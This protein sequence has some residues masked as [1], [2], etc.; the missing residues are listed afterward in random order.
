MLYVDRETAKVLLAEH[1]IKINQLV[2]E[3]E[4]K[5]QTLADEYTLKIIL[6]EIE[7]RE[8]ATASAVER[9]E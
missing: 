1:Q 7:F 4:E 8:K 2:K 5:S 3:H 9:G 6:L